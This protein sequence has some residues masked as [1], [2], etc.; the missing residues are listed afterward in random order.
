MDYL[1][2]IRTGFM[3]LNFGRSFIL[4]Q[5]QKYMQRYRENKASG[6]EEKRS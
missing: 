1:S 4:K 6:K 3:H 5:V 2:T